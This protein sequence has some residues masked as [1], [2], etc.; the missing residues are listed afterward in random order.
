VSFQKEGMLVRLQVHEEK[1]MVHFYDNLVVSKEL[2]QGN[3]VLVAQVMLVQEV[4]Q[5]VKVFQPEL[6]DVLHQFQEVFH[7]PRGL[8]PKRPMDHQIVLK[9]QAILVNKDLIGTIII[10]SWN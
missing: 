1:A 6:R 8:P 5:H 3:K 9:S 7:E 4:T 2:Q 10:R